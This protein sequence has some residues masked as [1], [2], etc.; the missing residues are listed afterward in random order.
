MGL[1][2]DGMGQVRGRQELDDMGQVHGDR[3]L[4]HGGMEQVCGGMEQVHGRQEHD[5]MGQVHGKQE[6]CGEVRW[7][8][9]H[10]KQIVVQIHGNQVHELLQRIPDQ[11]M[12]L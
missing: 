4:V 9:D 11:P 3:V 2:H 7:Y 10:L 6:L 1:V 5:Y 8:D 12:N